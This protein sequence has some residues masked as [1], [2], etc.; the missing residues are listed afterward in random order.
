[1]LVRCLQM[2]IKQA[3]A[4][5][6]TGDTRYSNTALSILE[7]WATTNKVFGVQKENGELHTPTVALSFVCTLHPF[8]YVSVWFWLVEFC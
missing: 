1:M 3:M 8:A 4:Y 6:A 2:A 5:W 7:A